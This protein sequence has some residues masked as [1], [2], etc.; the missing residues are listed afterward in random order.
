MTLTLSHG[1][2]LLWPLYLIPRAIIPA[3]INCS[4]GIHLRGLQVT[5]SL[6]GQI[7]C[8]LY[9]L[10][11]NWRC[12]MA[13]YEIISWQRGTLWVGGATMGGGGGG[14]GGNLIGILS[15]I[16][17]PT[18]WVGQD[19]IYYILWLH[20]H[21]YS[22]HMLIVCPMEHEEMYCICNMHM[23]T[24]IAIHIIKCSA[25]IGLTHLDYDHPCTTT[26][27]VWKWKWSDIVA[28]LLCAHCL[29]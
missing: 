26:N 21:S 11:V 12:F 15:I 16:G 5:R 6:S 9:R 8:T 18:H 14:R 23:C 20:G 27:Y 19:H 25:A 13:I 2:S 29:G 22:G 10:P 7:T 1:R 17:G 3:I 4:V 28:G 24:S